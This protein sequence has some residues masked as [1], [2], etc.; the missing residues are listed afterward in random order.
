MS[1]AV[2][3]EREAAVM[4]TTTIQ[5]HLAARG[6]SSVYLRPA[7]VHRGG[8]VTHERALI[9]I[10]QAMEEICGQ[11]LHPKSLELLCEVT[12]TKKV[13]KEPLSIIQLKRQPNWPLRRD[14]SQVSGSGQFVQRVA[15]STLGRLQHN[16]RVA[17]F[18][19]TMP[20]NRRDRTVLL[21]T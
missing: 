17:S 12:I 8:Q 7:G 21:R 19:C 2:D 15:S 11:A 13:W 16:L 1:T 4:A 6:G 20:K 5:T 14:G 18:Q 9:E 3:F 10:S